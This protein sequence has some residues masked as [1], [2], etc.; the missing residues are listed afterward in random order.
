[1]SEIRTVCVYC[2]SSDHCRTIFLESA[3]TL[4]N[5][6]AKESID[7][8]YGGG[9]TGL[10]GRLADG[11][12]A[13]NGHV[14]GIIPQFMQNLEW[15]HKGISIL[16][17]VEDMHTRKFLMIRKSD[18]IV[19]LPGGCGTLEELLEAITWKRLGLAHQPIVI[20]NID[21]FYDPLISMLQSTVDEQFM[22]PEHLNMWHVV[23][24][25]EEV[26][27]MLRSI[28]PWPLNAI[29]YAKV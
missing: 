22:R 12:I 1:M 28:D 29:S 5:I 27:P 7:I 3:Y 16:E 26:L 24:T 17:E 14:R 4:G 13:G 9:S 2:A 10:M 20:V 8:V 15:G 19:A 6:L 18:G 23:N 11:A 25:V 21:G